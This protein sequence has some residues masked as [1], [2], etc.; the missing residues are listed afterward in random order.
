MQLPTV[1]LEQLA[2]LPEIYRTVIPPEYE[3][4]N[5][6]MN[7]RWYLVIYDEAGDAM[8]RMIGLTDEYLAASGMGGFDLE[9]HIWYRSEVRVGDA[10]AIRLR[11]LA[12]TAKLC[13][14]LL[15]MTN[16]TRGNL[17]SL[18]ECLHAH[19]D[20][21][22]RRTAAFPP[23]TAAKVDALINGQRTLAWAAPVSGAIDI[24]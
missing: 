7:I 11:M 2:S 19:A 17:S 3:D 12:R 22:T 9:H 4:R 1:S 15:F 6:H 13:H 21:K 24:R 14:Y 5:R 10:V 20:L 18:F 8:Y 23:E 16:E